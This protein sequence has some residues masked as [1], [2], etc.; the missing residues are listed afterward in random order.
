MENN[1]LKVVGVSKLADPKQ[2]ELSLGIE[3]QIEIDGVG[4]GVLSDGT[5]FLTGR[6]LARLCGIRHFA[7]Q[8][9]TGEWL[10]QASK[11]RV[12]RLKEIL[13]S[14]NIVL[15][16]PY[17]EVIQN[18]AA[19]YAYPETF[20]LALLE[21]YS[22]DA[23][24]NVKEQAK[25]NYRLLAGKALRDF[26]YSQVGY[27][28]RQ[29]VPDAWRQ[30]HDRVSLTYNS[31]PAGYFG[32]FKEMAD[33]IVTLGQSG[34]HIDEKFVPDIS[35]GINWSKHWVAKDLSTSLGERIKYEHNYP[36]YFPQAMSN[37]QEPWCYPDAALGEFRRWVRYDYIGDGRF[38]KYLD[39]KVKERA[40]PA[41]FAQLAISAY[42]EE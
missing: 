12:T 22:L 34:L 24:S 6:G 1:G 5:P 13:A 15:Q 30:F 26:I 33:M 14:R 16:S 32:I 19:V 11:P 38:A 29:D 40:L 25:Q 21:Y 8:E 27:D 3:K 31:V 42:T 10:D 35:V 23:G 28:P 9:L 7:L 4:M 2:G 39:G 37:P 36:S 18:G 20:C 17:V 41:S